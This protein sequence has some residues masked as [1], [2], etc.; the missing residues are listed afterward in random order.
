MKHLVRT[1]GFMLVAIALVASRASAQTATIH[2]DLL[3]DWAMM[4]DTMTKIA[5]AMPE[6]KFGFKSTPVQRSFGEHVMHIAQINIMLLKAVGGKTA[7]PD[8]N[9]KATS[10]AETIKEM[11]A[12]FDYGTALLNEFNNQTIQDTIQAMFLGPS[13]RA[14]IFV[15]LMGHTMDTY[16]QMAVYLRLNGAVP[17]ASQRP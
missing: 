4:K 16:G 7:A 3:K 1:L 2:G 14:R 17:P 12:S 11:N 13:T 6:D 5:N 15:F 10:K 9:M 8:L